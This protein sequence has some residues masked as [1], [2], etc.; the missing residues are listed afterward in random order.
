MNDNTALEAGL[1]KRVLRFRLI[2]GAIALALLISSLV[3]FAIREETKEIISTDYPWGG[4]AEVKYD[5]DIDFAAKLLMGFFFIVL[6]LFGF[7]FI[8]GR[9]DTADV[10]GS[11]ITLYRGMASLELYVDGELADCLGYFLEGKLV[12]GSSVTVSVSRNAFSAHMSFSN[13]HPPIDL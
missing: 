10:G 3:L 9:V 6:V 1:R 5:L 12:D 11:R 8:Y 2:I 4:A 7:S 13:G